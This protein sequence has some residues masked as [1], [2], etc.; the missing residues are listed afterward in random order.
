MLGGHLYTL[1]NFTKNKLKPSFWYETTKGINECA[2]E[3]R[4]NF[5]YETTKGRNDRAYYLKP[6]FRHE[7]T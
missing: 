2:Y 7:A 5:W 6:N 1:T 4:P 3:L